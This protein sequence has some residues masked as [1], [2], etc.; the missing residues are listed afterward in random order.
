M[1]GSHVLQRKHSNEQGS[2]DEDEKGNEADRPGNGL[3]RCDIADENKDWCGH[4]VLNEDWVANH[5]DGEKSRF[6]AMSEAKSFTKVECPNW[7]HYIPRDLEEVEWDLVF[8]LLI[9]LNPS[10][11]VWERVGLGKVFRAAFNLT[12]RWEEVLLG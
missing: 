8:V 6:I 3:V 1:I 9:E 12:P 2:Q 11:L 5:Q 4:I 7:A 10:R